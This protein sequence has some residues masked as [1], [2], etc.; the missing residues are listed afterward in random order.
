[1]RRRDFITLMGCGV[2]AWPRLAR[3][4]AVM[5]P[6]IGYLSARSSVGDRSALAAFRQGLKQVGFVENESVWIDYCWADGQFDRLPALAADL[7]R[8]Q[9]GVIAA[10]NGTGVAQA[11]KAVTATIPIV[12]RNGRNP[13]EDG[14][15]ANLSRPEGNATGIVTDAFDLIGKRLEILRELLPEAAT[16]GVLMNPTTLTP[17]K[18]KTFMQAAVSNLDRAIL[19]FNAGTA[20]EIDAAFASAV[21]R[22]VESLLV[23]PDSMF[24]RMSDRIVALAASYQIPTNYPTRGFA[25][26]GG[27]MSYG[28]DRRESY[29][30]AGIYVGRILNGETP[31]DLPV[32]QHTKFELV[33]NLKTAAALGR[34]VPPSLLA[35]ADELIG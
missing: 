24:R 14:L 18:F 21:R 35:R 9:V 17:E 7:I 27:L 15:V 5:M 31:G 11:A 19:V 13:V 6:T 20:D 26:A 23:L 16:I 32:L 3:A 28:Y 12:F 22:G 33:I 34:T 30:Q 29:C 8:R 1:M 10:L 4:R 2:A 25:E